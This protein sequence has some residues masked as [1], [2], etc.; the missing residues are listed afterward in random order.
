VQDDPRF[1]RDGV[2]LYAPV[3]V[4]MFTAILGGEVEVT[5]ISGRVKLTIP[6]GTQPEQKIRIAGRGM[7][8]LKN[9]Q[10][11]GDLFVQVKVS[12][13]KNLTAEQKSFLQK[14]RELEK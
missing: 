3:S 7:P 4:D 10:V 1:E 13:P 6:P 9:P 2:D 5:T 11:K 8:Q 14:A 12:V